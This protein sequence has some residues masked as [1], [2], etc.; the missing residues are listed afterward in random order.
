MAESIYFQWQNEILCKSIYPMRKEKLRD[1]LV[2]YQ[3]IDLWA[4][5]TNK[6]D[7]TTDIKEFTEA[8][9]L[10]AI[11]AYKM[12]SSTRRYCMQPDVRAYYLRFKPI[13]EEELT[14]I[15]N[16]HNTFISYWP[17]DIRGERDFVEM[18]IQE[19]TNHYKQIQDWI[20]SRKRRLSAMDP[21]HPKYAPETEELKQKENVALPMAENEL[22]R[23]YAFL[24]TYDKIEKRKLDWY[25]MQKR[26]QVPEGLTEAEFLVT[27]APK[28]PP[29]AREIVQWKAQTYEE[30]L[31]KKD[32]YELLDE[33]HQRFE[34]EPE[35]YPPWLQYMIVHFSGM[36]YASAHGSW[37]DPKDL[38]I[39]M[40]IPEVEEEIK[41]LDDETVAKISQE[42]ISLYETPPAGDGPKP[43]LTGAQ[44]Q[45]WRNVID[46][47]LA[48]LKSS[49]PSTRR[50]GL[51]DIRKF[52]L[53]FAIRSLST[54][55][56]LDE[57][58][59]KR[60]KF[61]EWAWKEI[62]RLTP[63]R[64][65]EVTAPDWEKLTP[66]EEQESY[67]RENYPVRA[68]IDAWK[69]QDIT[70]WREE[71]GRT[72]ELIVS[73]A[74]CNETA[75]HIQHL[76]GYLL[77]GGLTARPKW[78]LANEKE[79]KIPGNPRPYFVKAKTAQE[80]T[81]GASV[82][83]LRFVDKQPDA[84]QVAK[85]IETKDK[86]GLLPDGFTGR[87]KEGA[88]KD[89]GW[90]YKMGEVITR[91]RFTVSG[92]K[93]DK[94]RTR[95]MQFL[96]WMHEATVIEVAETAEGTVVL[97]FETALP[98]DYKGTSSIG[99]FKKP[100]QYFLSDGEED[101]YNRSFV[102]YVPEGQV[103]VEHIKMMLDWNKILINPHHEIPSAATNGGRGS[104]PHG[105]IA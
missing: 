77:P 32:Q 39:R 35:R 4:E 61:P 36:R 25:W 27:Y 83:W 38:L 102:G 43:R 42:K 79:D 5:Y 82:L 90:I 64:A 99:I 70:G 24:G 73:R 33:I 80:Y 55:A 56:A 76:R 87:K 37:A 81:P 74:V 62:V 97:T 14:A 48:N 103:P 3:E 100:L 2:F 54:Q 95:E 8:Q 105:F 9:R 89:T 104:R 49:S 58:V 26:G 84:W 88:N 47:S 75:E 44:G 6:Q 50:R 67:L 101:F 65:T 59:E 40:R 18:R 23:L 57:L 93:E 15:N 13:N 85:P 98:D 68:I 45:E 10:S 19:W 78:Y 22:D 96:R 72:H 91:E 94:K 41:N 7:L 12:Y 11:A 30:S 21:G 51:I 46:W 53:A 71:H 63:L 31:E 28:Q 34:K 1:F 52:E 29:T 92:K 69:N 86:V 17:K 66:E 16:L 60:D 20:K